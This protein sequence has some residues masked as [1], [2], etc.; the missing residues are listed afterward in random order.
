MPSFFGRAYGL[1]VKSDIALPELAPAPTE[2]AADLT[3]RL[4]AVDAPTEYDGHSTARWTTPAEFCLVYRDAGAYLIRTGREIVIDPLPGVE[5]RLVRLYLLGPA[6]A[7]ALHQ[8][9]WLVLHASAVSLGGTVAGFL[10][11]SSWG[12]STMAATLHRRGHLLVADDFLAVAAEPDHVGP[13]LIYPGFPQLKLWPEAAASTG[14]DPSHLPQLRPDLEKRAR[15]L[16]AGFAAEP[17]PLGQLYVLEEGETIE[18]AP[19]DRQAALLELVRHSYAARALPRLDA[20]S[21]LRQCAALLRHVPVRRL[22]RPRDLNAL[23]AVAECVEGDAQPQ[24]PR[25]AHGS[26]VTSR[27]KEASRHGSA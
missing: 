6:L 18:V 8:R 2:A 12:K 10:G 15:R 7:L 26:P 4:G 16:E 27:P 23:D 11:G 25:P 3:V 5:E 22:R 21:H 17:L 19:L 14:A 1:V 24:P 20:S 9:G 13:I